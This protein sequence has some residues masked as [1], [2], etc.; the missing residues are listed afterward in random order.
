MFASQH[1]NASNNFAFDRDKKKKKKK[2]K[3]TLVKT[4]KK[5]K[6]KWGKKPIYNIPWE[7]GSKGS[8]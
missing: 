7:K 8:L 6:K 1:W 5:I 4:K 2:K 3:K